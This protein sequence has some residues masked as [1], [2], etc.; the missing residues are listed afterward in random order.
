MVERDHNLEFERY[1]GA[2]LYL[3]TGRLSCSCALQ[4]DGFSGSCCVGR[5][6]CLGASLELPSDVSLKCWDN[7]DEPKK[8]KSF[9]MHI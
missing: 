3:F 6:L 1:K 8:E 2:C 5:R 7:R 4:P 9:L